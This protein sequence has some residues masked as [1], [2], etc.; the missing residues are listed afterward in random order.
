MSR[1]VPRRFFLGAVACAFA[2][3][4]LCATPAHATTVTV[5]GITVSNGSDFGVADFTVPSIGTDPFTWND[6]TAVDVYAST[7]SHPYLGTI[8]NLSVFLSDPTV[9]LG[10]AVTAGPVATTFSINSTTV[11]FP[12]L[13]N[14]GGFASAGITLTSSNPPFGTSTLMGLFPGSKAYEAQYNGASSVFANLV[15]PITT[16]TSTTNSEQFP[17]V[18]GYSPIAATVSD[19]ESQFWFTLSSQA[20]ASGTS[21]FTV[22]PEPSSLLLAIVGMLGLLWRFRRRTA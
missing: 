21:S 10:F 2:A 14:P 16:T 9:S 19:I 8:D 17:V 7:G 1:A 18:P 15:S 5:V 4:L 12:P 3:A 20:S 22:V 11:S 13:V 6:N